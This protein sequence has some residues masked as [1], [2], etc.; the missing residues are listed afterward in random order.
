MWAAETW[1]RWP[2]QLVLAHIVLLGMAAGGFR[3]M[4]LLPSVY[5]IWAKARLVHVICWARIRTI[6]NFAMGANKCTVDVAARLFVRAQ[7]AARHPE[8]AVVT[9]LVD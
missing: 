6:P 8:L 1:R 2:S 7:A 3:P 5:R 9:A 4:A